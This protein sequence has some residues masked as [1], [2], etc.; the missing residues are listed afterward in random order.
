M[1]AKALQTLDPVELRTPN[2]ADHTVMSAKDSGRRSALVGKA[3]MRPEQVVEPDLENRQDDV[4]KNGAASLVA[5]PGEQEGTIP[6][7]MD[8]SASPPHNS[9]PTSYKVC[10]GVHKS[11]APASYGPFLSIHMEHRG[12]GQIHPD[13][14]G[15]FTPLSGLPRR[16]SRPVQ[17]AFKV[18]NIHI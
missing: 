13:F 14:P 12:D 17:V 8:V 18:L 5:R 15:L 9:M 2:S 10:S 16:E 3:G 1:Q 6:Q 7:P 4:S 11:D